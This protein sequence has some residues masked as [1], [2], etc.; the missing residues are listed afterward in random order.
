M[1]KVKFTCNLCGAVFSKWRGQC[2][3]CKEWNS[4]VED[5]IDAIKPGVSVEQ[6]PEDFFVTLSNNNIQSIS[7]RHKTGINEL[8]RV[9]GGG[10]VDGSVILLGGSPGI[11]KSTLLLQI[12]SSISDVSETVYISAEESTG[13]I[14]MRAQR[15]DINNTKLKVASSSSIDQILTALQNIQPKSLVIMDSIQTVCSESIASPPGSISQVRYCT[16]ELVNFTKSHDIIMIIVGHVTKDGTIAGPKTLEHMVDVVLSFDGDRTS[17]YRI[18]RGDKNRYGAIDEIGVFAMTNTGLREVSNPS[19]AFLSEH[20]NRTSGVAVFSGIEGTRPIL[21]EIQA[22]VSTSGLQIPRR[23]AVGFDSNRLAMIVAVLS[24]RCRIR[25]SNKDIYINVA[26]GLKITEPAADLAVAAAII[27]STLKVPL[28]SNSV[29]FGELGLSGDIRQAYLAFT[30]LKEAIKLGFT[31]IYCSYK[32]E[33][34]TITTDTLNVQ[35]NKIKS[36]RELVSFCGNN[37]R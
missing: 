16:L 4:V 14:L 24:N 22:L 23:A 5:V 2:D 11:G 7:G 12:A 36:I 33:N 32:T 10:L 13:Q 6:V 19:A 35:I 28:P 25:F 27:S 9:L 29:F 1:T 20:H 26:G 21:S 15:L 37:N 34:L 31:N 8:D 3:I 18:L 30:R 17:D